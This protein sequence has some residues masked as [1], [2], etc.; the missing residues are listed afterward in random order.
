VNVSPANGGTITSPS[1]GNLVKYPASFTCSNSYV[2]TAVPN[3]SANYKFDRWGGSVS[4]S[5]NPITVKAD[6]VK[7]VTAYFVFKTNPVALQ[8]AKSL[9]DGSKDVLVVDVSSASNFAASHILCAK[10]Y[11]WNSGSNS[12]ATSI[13]NLG[14]YKEDDILLYEQNGANIAAAA[15]YLAGQ[16]FESLY[17]MT[18]GLD[19]WI[20]EGYETFTTAEDAV[21]C[22]SLPPLAY[23]G[24]DQDVDE[25]QK[26]TLNGSGP[27][28]A[29]YAWTQV[30]GSTVSLSNPA[31]Q[32]PTFTS[33]DL[34]GSDGELIFH[35]TVT[36][37]GKKD[38]DSVTV[39]VNWNNAAPNANAGPDQTVT[40]GTLVSLNGSGS[41]D[42]ENSIKS[43]QWTA[44]SG[45]IS[46]SLLNSTTATP[47]FT[48]PATSGW[49]LYE[50]TVT[51][52]GDLTDTDTVKIT[53]QAAVVDPNN[54]PEAN[55]G[56]DQTVKEGATVILDSSGSTDTDGTIA[57]RSWTQTGGTPAVTLPNPAAIKPIF[58]APDVSASTVLTF[59]LTVTDD[60][61]AIDMDTVSVTVND[62]TTPPP[63]QNVAPTADAGS[64]QSV[65][66]NKTV[67]LDGS[68]STDSDGTIASYAWTQTDSTGITVVLSNSSAAKPT[69]TA[70]DVDAATTLTFALIVTDNQGASSASDTVSVNV[71]ESSG[72]GGGG[73]CFINSLVD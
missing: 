52:N 44:S 11:V 19:D 70:P 5:T 29:S 13:T 28:G 53:V 57:S 39:N 9:V 22:S 33:P 67:T 51:D 36:D 47:S 61:G 58:T 1:F 50:L 20:A 69:F 72:G 14:L 15:D 12:F 68:G 56:A 18:D 21:N 8:G 7:S 34:N 4:G 46:P 55:A 62:D 3:S 49:V 16:G 25:N 41:T 66:E 23:A 10:N 71:T 48:A 60:D 38:T 26:V 40:P 31:A 27:I 73:G 45:T 64:A 2:L 6:A 37:G 24:V 32:K 59:T 65:K 30:E 42:D 17:Y 63:A 43:Y 35:L 54:P